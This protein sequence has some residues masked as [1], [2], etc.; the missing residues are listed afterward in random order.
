MHAAQCLTTDISTVYKLIKV[1]NNRRGSVFTS[2]VFSIH[3]TT[4]VFTSSLQIVLHNW[5]CERN[6][7]DNT[8]LWLLLNYNLI[9]NAGDGHVILL[10]SNFLHKVNHNFI[11]LC[12]NR[13]RRTV[14]KNQISKKASANVENC[15]IH[16]AISNC[17]PTSFKY[18]VSLVA[19]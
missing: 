12:I 11:I 16:S 8:R 10:F 9:P 4:A 1:K 13:N 3:F 17:R 19:W 6:G 5:R 14:K 7:A 15:R 2:A 18:M